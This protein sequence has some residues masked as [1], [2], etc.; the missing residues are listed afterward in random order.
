VLEG[1]RRIGY[2]S[3]PDFY[4]AWGDAEGGKSAG[5]VAAEILKL[6]KQNIDGLILDVR[7]NGGGSLAEAV[8]MTGIFIEAGPVGIERVKGQ[9]AFTIKDQNRGTVYDGPLTILINSMSA[10]ASEFLAAALQD[11]RRAIIVGSNTF[12]KGTAQEMFSLR[13]GKPDVDFANLSASGWGFVKVTTGKTYRIN[14]KAIQRRG[15]V[16]DISLPDLSD[17]FGY[18]ESDQDYALR[19]DSVNKKTYWTPLAKLPLAALA[20]RSKD[21]VSGHAGFKAITNYTQS[22]AA[23]IN[24]ETARDWNE[25]KKNMDLQDK[26]HLN[27]KS[28]VATATESFEVKTHEF[29]KPRMEVDDYVDM[30]NKAW[31]KNL[32]HDISLEEAFNITCDYIDILNQN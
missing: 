25:A 16:P 3:L 13:P 32:S 15:V 2:I 20:E 31:I 7:F 12:G 1:K 4:S 28:A 30:V 5:D 24:E 19:S 11:Y 29:G 17:T 22:V 14:G 9:E 18:R 6:K 27:L 26:L 21:R 23:R 8:N 10:S